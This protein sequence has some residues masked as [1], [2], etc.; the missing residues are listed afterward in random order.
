MNV[1]RFASAEEVVTWAVSMETAGI[2]VLWIG[3]AYGF[4]A[5]SMLGL[6][7]GRTSRVQ[8]GSAILPV[9][10]RSP[11]LTAMTAAGRDFVSSGRFM[12]GLGASGPEVVQGWHGAA[13]DRPLLRT[14]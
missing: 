6:L 2:D 3:E 4:D 8:L 11:A 1:P 7:A 12:L 9:F 14:R 13:Y 10:S 5:L